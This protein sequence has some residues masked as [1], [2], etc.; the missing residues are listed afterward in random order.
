MNDIVN[1]VPYLAANLHVAPATLLFWLFVFRLSA[2]AGARLIP[3]DA[4][5]WKGSLRKAC[6]FAGIHIS[7]RITSDQKASDIL[8]ECAIRS[9]SEDQRKDRLP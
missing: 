5:G 1:F 6:A 7:D 2:N 3:A 4:V 9:K 8:K